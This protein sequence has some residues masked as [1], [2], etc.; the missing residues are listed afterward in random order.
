MWKTNLVKKMQINL[1]YLLRQREEPSHSFQ[2]VMLQP[3]SH[4]TFSQWKRKTWRK[5]SGRNKN[6]RRNYLKRQ[7]KDKKKKDKK[8]RYKKKDYGD[9]DDS[10]KDNNGKKDDGGNIL[11][12]LEATAV[13]ISKIKSKQKLRKRNRGRDD[14]DHDEAKEK[15]S[16]TKL[17]EGASGSSEKANDPNM[18]EG[19]ATKGETTKTAKDQDDDEDMLQKRKAKF[20]EIMEKGNARTDAVFGSSSLER[21]NDAASTKQQNNSAE[22]EK[23]HDDEGM[24]DDEQDDAFLNAA[25]AKARRLRRLRELNTA[26]TG[27]ATK[28]LSAENSSKRGADAIAHSVK[29]ANLAASKLSN[30]N[31]VEFVGNDN[32]GHSANKGLTFEFDETREFTRALRAKAEQAERPSKKP[33]KGISITTVNQNKG[34]GTK[35]GSGAEDEDMEDIEDMKELAQQIKEDE[36]E[37]YNNTA[38]NSRG[39]GST[40]EVEPVGRGVSGVLNLLRH[41]GEI[42]RKHAG[43]EELRGRAKDKRTYEDYESLNLKEVVKI[44]NKNAQEKDVEFANREIKLEYRDDFGRL[45]TRKE[46][47]RQLCYQFHGYGSS[48]KNEERRLRQIAREHVEGTLA[49]RQVGGSGES[50]G[51]KGTLGALKMAQRAS[52]KAFVVHRT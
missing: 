34:E 42:T 43:K 36:D 7:K 20:D 38:V 8:S 41:T 15:E 47:Y 30:N 27:A 40:A 9:D 11:D 13:D 1:I 17:E 50:E 5:R 44:D 39:F 35:T 28:I 52:G 6:V 22:T 16:K 45:L 46:A 19:E 49:S 10:D 51:G 33:R 31:A 14:D 25:L 12:D 32:D 3:I 21:K 48:K 4:P 29:M 23:G 24:A 26:A 2:I 18:E 37:D